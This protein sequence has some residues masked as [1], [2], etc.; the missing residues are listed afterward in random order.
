MTGYNKNTQKSSKPFLIVHC[1][2]II[3][4]WF[5][6]FLRVCSQTLAH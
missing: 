5:W 2:G 6:I 1:P 3:P 4:C